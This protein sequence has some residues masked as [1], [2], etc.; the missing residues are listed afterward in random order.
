MNLF[1]STNSGT[2]IDP[3]PN[4]DTEPF[5]YTAAE[6]ARF[7]LRFLD[8]PSRPCPAL[9]PGGTIFDTYLTSF[10]AATKTATVYD[11]W[12]WGYR[13]VPGPSTALLISVGAGFLAWTMPRRNGRFSP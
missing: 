12:E 2:H 1:I 5:Y 4:D 10:N 11:G 6:R 8:N 3:F 13:V 9:C 7:G